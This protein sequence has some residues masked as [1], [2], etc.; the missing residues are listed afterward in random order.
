MRAPHV[1]RSLSLSESRSRRASGSCSSWPR[2]EHYVARWLDDD[3][4]SSNLFTQDRLSWT[5]TQPLGLLR[6]GPGL[7]GPSR[8]VSCMIPL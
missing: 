6:Q 2:V 4:T 1:S 8:M 3:E 7:C 5:D